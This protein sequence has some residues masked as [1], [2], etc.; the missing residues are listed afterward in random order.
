MSD[1]RQ[2]DVLCRLAY[3]IQVATGSNGVHEDALLTSADL[4]RQLQLRHDYVKK[5]LR[6][7]KDMGLI[8]PVGLNPKRYRFD[9]FRYRQ[10]LLV[11]TAEDA[12]MQAV[13]DS[14]Q[15]I[16]GEDDA[17]TAPADPSPT[18]WDNGW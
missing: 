12:T 9:T 11:D 3:E 10:L 1:S 13:M 5:Q 4:A 2:I 17:Q 8:L 15:Q 14:L 6:L 7:L 16:V 18:G